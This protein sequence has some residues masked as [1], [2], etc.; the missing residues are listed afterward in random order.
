M[1]GRTIV[2]GNFYP[3]GKLMGN[4]LSDPAKIVGELLS[5]GTFSHKYIAIFTTKCVFVVKFQES[6]ND[7]AVIK[8]AF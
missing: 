7:F 1:F 4:F 2:W 5:G 8:C 6:E 3:G